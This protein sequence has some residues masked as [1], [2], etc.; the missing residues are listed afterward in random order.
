M[1]K[2]SGFILMLIIVVSIIFVGCTKSQTTVQ[3][4][5]VGT[6]NVEDSDTDTIVIYTFKNESKKDVTVIGGARYKMVKDNK[7]VEEG[8]VPIKD[9]ITLEPGQDYTDKKTFSNLKSGSYSIDM[10]WN[11]TIVTAK[12]L[13]N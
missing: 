2:M 10:E 8:G 3:S 7:D 1:T 4:D 12:F 13:R 5:L 11:N 6:V 9:Y